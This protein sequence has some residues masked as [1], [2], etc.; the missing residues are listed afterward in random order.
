V[1]DVHWV[2]PKL[3]AE[4]GFAEWTEDGVLRHPTFIGLRAD[5]AA[6]EVWREPP[7]SPATASKK[8]AAANSTKQSKTMP[9][10]AKSTRARDEKPAARAASNGTTT[11]AGVTLS[12]ADK[13]L[14][15]ESGITKLDLAR[16]YEAVAE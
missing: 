13:V 7:Q 14:Y 6:L 16:Y 11:I 12:K 10:R 15:P 3:V 8:Q 2:E 1:R 9:S 4:I 5:K